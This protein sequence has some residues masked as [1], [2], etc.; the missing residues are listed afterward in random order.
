[1][2]NSIYDGETYDA[3]LEKAGWDQSANNPTSISADRSDRWQTAVE[4]TSPGG[5]L[6]AQTL[7][8]IKVVETRR[9]VSRN[10]PRPGVFVFDTGQNLAGWAALRVTGNR[11]TTITLRFAES[12]RED[13]TI[14]GD[15]LRKARALDTYILKGDGEE[16]WEPRFTYHGF[17]YVQVEG[18]PGAPTLDD[19]PIRV[20]RSSVMES[21]TFSCSNELLNRI[22]RMVTWTEAS[23][24]HSVPTDC[25]QRDERMG[26]LNDMTVR[27]EP[28]LYRFRL[29]RFYD[30]WLDDVSDTQSADGAITDTAPFQWGKRPADP[31]SASYLLL[32]WQNYLHYGDTE[33]MREHYAHFRRWVDYLVSRSVDG[34]LSYSNWGD[35]APPATVAIAGSI[36]AGA[37]SAQTPGELISTGFLYYQATLLAQMA[38]VLGKESERIELEQLAAR[39]ARAFNEKFWN[40]T[41]GGY[42]SN[43]QACNAFALFLGLTP[44]GRVPRIVES[45]LAAV[46]EKNDHLSTGNLCSKYLLE[47]LT[48]HG[49]VDVAYRIATQTTY[50][51]W[52]FMLENGAT[53]LWERWEHLTG[54]AMNSHNHPMLGSVGSWFFKY[55]AGI[56]VEAA[57]AGFSHVVIEPHLPEDLQ[58]AEGSYHTM[59]GLIRSAWRRDGSRVHLSIS[60]PANTAATVRFPAA[61]TGTVTERGKPLDA[62]EGV[63]RASAQEAMQVIELGSGD[64]EFLIVR[65]RTTT[66]PPPNLNPP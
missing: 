29:A 12:L 47:M 22:H 64:Y 53:T 15:N 4:V 13:G 40:E 5:A 10:E 61:A 9:A 35:W 32:A 18:W 48:E 54:G 2:E 45:L 60:I 42:G 34:I 49:H 16:T 46:R 8:P 58:W 3:R 17:R 62:V 20:V 36:G 65:D 23:N 7:E 30:K 21:G 33:P 66:T 50:P 28:A 27:I 44:P 63:A 59:R 41:A 43:N 19:L 26:W 56:R 52:G 57:G 14:N 31:V 6:V 37:L 38:R 39:V 51:S 11:G 55:L 25:P 24:L 1:V